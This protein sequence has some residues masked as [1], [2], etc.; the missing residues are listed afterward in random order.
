MGRTQ[1]PVCDVSHTPPARSGSASSGQ[2][3]VHTEHTSACGE[4]VHLNLSMRRV[5][6]RCR[7]AP[8]RHILLAMRT[9]R[10]NRSESSVPVPTN[11]RKRKSLTLS[12]STH[13]QPISLF[14]STLCPFLRPFC[15]IELQCYS[16][17]DL[18]FCRHCEIL[19][20]ASVNSLFC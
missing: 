4:R 9:F 19:I 12:N 14:L 15:S 13:S 10:S 16:R 11:P 5:D 18:R 20:L 1:V 7:S 17:M 6:C 8:S 3:T 2:R